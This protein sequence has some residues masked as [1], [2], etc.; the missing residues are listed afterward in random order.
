M[1]NK[2]RNANQ[3][4]HLTNNTNHLKANDKQDENEEFKNMQ[5]TP[6][7]KDYDEIEY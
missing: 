3:S 2:R 1:S 7:P 5:P 6:Q 4:S